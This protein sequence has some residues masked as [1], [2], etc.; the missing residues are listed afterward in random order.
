MDE[1][2]Q[3]SKAAVSLSGKENIYSLIHFA[4]VSGG[5]THY[6]PGQCLGDGDPST[7]FTRLLAADL[8]FL[9]AVSGI[10]VRSKRLL[11]ITPAVISSGIFININI[12]MEQKLL[13]HFTEGKVRSPEDD[14][15]TPLHCAVSSPRV[16][17]NPQSH[18]PSRTAGAEEALG[19][20][21]TC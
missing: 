8:R 2:S 19:S 14:A 6:V 7:L 4:N 13:S 3:F 18:S 21:G 11:P 9:H 16:M 15:L 1:L 17:F 20:Y 10:T 12:I 5:G